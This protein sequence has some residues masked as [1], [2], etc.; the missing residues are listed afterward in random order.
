M[1]IG[2]MIIP[3]TVIVRGIK[4]AVKSIGDCAFTR[5]SSLTSVTIPNSVTYIGGC[6]FYESGLVN[7]SIPNSVKYVGDG[8]FHEC[9]KLQLNNYGNSSYL[10]NSENPYVLLYSSEME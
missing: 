3:D 9:A 6:A 4:Y 2:N 8:A 10:G 5:C 7:V 1:P